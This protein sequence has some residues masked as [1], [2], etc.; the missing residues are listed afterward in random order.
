MTSQ[1]MRLELPRDAAIQLLLHVTGLSEEEEARLRGL[2][3]TAL[4][5]EMAEPANVPAL[6]AV[7]VKALQQSLEENR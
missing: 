4:D 3:D 2:S 5:A 6:S 1:S 7:V